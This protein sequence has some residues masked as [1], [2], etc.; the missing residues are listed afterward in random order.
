MDVKRILLD[1]FN[2]STTVCHEVLSGLDA[3]AANTQPVPGANS[4]T[5]LVWHIAREQDAQIAQLGGTEEVW[6]AQGWY[7]RFGLDLPPESIGYGHTDAEASKVRV[8]DTGLLLEYLVATA[9]ATIDYV[10]ELDETELDV[11]IDR[12]WCPPVTTAVRL[13]SIAD[14]AAQHAGQAAYVRGLL[15]RRQ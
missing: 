9:M 1:A 6:T 10:M 14:D 15:E 4:I 12:A 7:E 11:I 3:E 13:V 8:D 5:W 2:R